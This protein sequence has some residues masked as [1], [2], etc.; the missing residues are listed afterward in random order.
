MKP[1]ISYLM[2][3]FSTLLLLGIIMMS[4]CLDA[5]PPGSSNLGS[6]ISDCSTKTSD[7]ARTSCYTEVAVSKGDPS[8]CENLEDYVLGMNNCYNEVAQSKVDESICMMIDGEQPQVICLSRIGKQ[9]NDPS[10]CDN[11]ESDLWK[12]QCVAAVNK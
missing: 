4:G 7:I 5:G 1:N 9:K 6:S 12:N 2:P 3:A 8:V 11:L 10:V